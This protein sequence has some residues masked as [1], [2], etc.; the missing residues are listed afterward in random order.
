MESSRTPR[1]TPC[2]SLPTFRTQ[3]ILWL[4]ARGHRQWA[5]EAEEA[6]TVTIGDFLK[7][8][9]LRSAVPIW[10]WNFVTKIP[11]LS[12][13]LLRDAD[14]GRFASTRVHEMRA[15]SNAASVPAPTIAPY[16][17]PLGLPQALLFVRLVARAVLEDASSRPFPKTPKSYMLPPTSTPIA[18]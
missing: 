8:G 18:R 17:T 9:I 6:L 4:F 1:R 7:R 3:I 14:H 16:H 10:A 5:L 13:K 12:L 11:S 2:L 15:Q